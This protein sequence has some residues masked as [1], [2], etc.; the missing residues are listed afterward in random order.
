MRFIVDSLKSPALRASSAAPSRG[1]RPDRVP[2]LAAV[3]GS[4][5]R[6]RPMM[7]GIVRV[8]SPRTVMPAVGKHRPERYDGEV[9]A[10]PGQEWQAEALSARRTST[11]SPVRGKSLLGA[12]QSYHRKRIFFNGDGNFGPGLQFRANRGGWPG[13]RRSAHRQLPGGAPERGAEDAYLPPAAHR[14]GAG[15]R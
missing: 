5:V 7:N 13:T 3:A 10:A 9:P 2:R 8:P 4:D 14:P 12:G 15:E 11:G 6:P 1:G